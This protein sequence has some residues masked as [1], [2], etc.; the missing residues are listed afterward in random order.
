MQ[1]DPGDETAAL[2]R[3]LIYKIDNTTFGNDTPTLPQWSGPPSTMVHVQVILFASLAISLFSAFLAM[4][5]KQWLNRYDSTD[6]RG[7]TVER[8]QNRQRK[9]DGVV[10]WF[11]DYVMESL[12]LMLQISLL[13]LGCALS[14]Y[15]W[16][17]SIIVASIVIGVT[18]FGLLFYMFLVVAGAASDSC[19]YQTPG[20][21]ILRYLWP[22]IPNIL[23]SA[24]SAVGSVLSVVL[25]ALGGTFMGSQ[26]MLTIVLSSRNYYPWWRPSNVMPFL[27]GLILKIPLALVADVYDLLRV[28]V[29]R[30]AYILNRAYYLWFVIV[31]PVYRSC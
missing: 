24:I 9:L 11:F 16:G 25:L 1:P 17:I 5:G 22:R 12:P 23:Y 14:R 20:S 13:L 6:R 7:T 15:L 8:N 2:L 28:V 26:V 30:S 4:L 27:L 18:S 3:V 29:R 21:L 19:P 31:Q 10:S